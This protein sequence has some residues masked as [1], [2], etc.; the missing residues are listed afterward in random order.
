MK[1][2]LIHLIAVVFLL[3]SGPKTQTTT[4]YVD[5][6][7]GSDTNSGT[8]ENAP[9]KTLSKVNEMSSEFA[10][11]DVIRLKKGEIWKGERIR[12]TTHPSGTSAAPITY[13]SYGSGAKPIID[14]LI[15][16]SP[17]W[18]NEEGNI[19]STETDNYARFFRNGV[20]MLRTTVYADLGKFGYEYFTDSGK[21][22]IYS[23]GNPSTDTFS[24]A[25]YSDC[26]RLDGADYIR[27][28]GLDIRGG[29]SS[30]LRINRNHGWKISNCN[31]G[32]NAGYGIVV[33]FSSNILIEGLT[34][35]ANST[36]DQS[37]IPPGGQEIDYTGCSDGIFVAK[38]SSNIT[39]RNCF[40]KNWSHA[41]FGSN[42]DDPL[43]KISKIKFYNNELTAPDIIYGG[44]IAYSG[45]SEDGEY[46]N[47][48]IHEIAVA[49]QLGG[50]RNHFHHNIIDGIIDSTLK[51]EL[52]GIGIWL[53]NYNI[54]VK[55]NII[56]NN[57]IANTESKGFEIYSVN[58]KKP[59]EVS[60]NIFRNNI[61][62]N[63]GIT[64]DNIAIQFHEDQENEKIYNNIIENNLIYNSK[65]TKTCLFQYNGPLS[66]VSTFNTQHPDIR[67]NI[68]GDPLFVDI[69]NG[70]YHLRANSPA[71][72][73]GITPLA[74]VDYAG[75]PI[76]NGTSPD[77]GIY[78]S[79][80]VPIP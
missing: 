9:W 45:Y 76:P 30:S 14:V 80:T 7:H 11:G 55:D 43:N 61:L 66:D 63:C 47:N 78:E 44:R 73:A 54:Q 58:F 69:E 2:K 13:T 28:V 8:S 34:L 40:F 56:E 33:S 38:G 12:S 62:Y 65:S 77:I 48:Y 21:L 60:G 57:I 20:E 25:K 26:F 1:K 31:I 72:D 64:E 5:A 41:S 22:Y 36:V 51:N 32:K 79:L 37:A 49:N 52:I 4:Y 18:K 59:N 15:E 6:T 10:P 17:V 71:I 35:D 74:T 29:S 19:W 75:N 42:T 68:A 50:S 46:Y 67:N 23:T 3:S 70:D 53:L 16:Q 39:I 24:W 27:V